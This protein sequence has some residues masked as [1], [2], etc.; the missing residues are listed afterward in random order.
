[1]KEAK[2]ACNKILIT[3]HVQYISSNTQHCI[4]KYNKEIIL[5]FLFIYLLLGLLSFVTLYTDTSYTNHM[6]LYRYFYT[7]Y[8]YRVAQNSRNI[9]FVCLLRIIRDFCAT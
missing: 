2:N 4:I 6:T 3:L 8:I 9:F 1:M 5:F 7:N